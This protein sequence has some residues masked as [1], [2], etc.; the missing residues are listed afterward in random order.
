M[1]QALDKF[2]RKVKIFKYICSQELMVQ[3]SIVLRLVF[4]SRIVN[5]QCHMGEF[6]TGKAAGKLEETAHLYDWTGRSRASGT[7]CLS[8]VTRRHGVDSSASTLPPS[9]TASSKSAQHCG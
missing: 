8:Q 4:R 9:A 5:T 6:S 2:S 3:P 7:Q 1:V